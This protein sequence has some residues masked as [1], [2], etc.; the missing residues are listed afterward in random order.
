MAKE[1]FIYAIGRRKTSSARV[2]L[3]SATAEGEIVVN[4]KSLQ[5]YFP[6]KTHQMVIHQPL[7]LCERLGKYDFRVTVA[8]GGISGQTGAVLLGISRA[9]EKR[10]PELRAELKKAGFLTRDSRAVERKKPGRHKA[11][12]RPQFS[13]R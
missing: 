6:R 3:K 11:R 1:Q 9:L 5:E 12:K 4:G 7:E 10:E 13:K 8:G 2:F